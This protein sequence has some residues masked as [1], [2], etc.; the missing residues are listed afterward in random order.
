M[1]VAIMSAATLADLACG[2]EK[3]LPGSGI[4]FSLPLVGGVRFRAEPARY[5]HNLA[6]GL[7]G[8]AAATVNV[9]SLALLSA[10]FPEPK[11]KALA[12]GIWTAIAN[13]ATA[14]GP[15]PWAVSSCR[16]SAGAAFSSLILPVGLVVLYLTWRHVG[17]SRVWE[18]S[19][20]F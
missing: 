10:A 20:A 17:E 16:A 15:R 7:Q 2:E 9:A 3:T 19:A 5:P 13:V 4:S 12:I 18:A 8:I 14:V 6:R 11:Q 1:A